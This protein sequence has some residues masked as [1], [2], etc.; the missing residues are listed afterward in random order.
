MAMVIVAAGHN[1][2]GQ[3]WFG[4]QDAAATEESGDIFTFTKVLEGH[5]LSRPQARLA[6]T[7]GM[8]NI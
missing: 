7:N 1:A 3:L 8:A 2:W 5:N 6:Y 4:D